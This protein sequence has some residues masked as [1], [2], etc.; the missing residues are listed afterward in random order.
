MIVRILGEGQFELQRARSPRWRS[1]TRTVAA[2]DAK[3]RRTF[4]DVLTRWFKKGAIEGNARPRIVFVP[5]KLTLATRERVTHE[6]RELLHPR[7]S[8]SPEPLVIPHS[9]S[10]NA[11]SRPHDSR[12][13][14]CR[15][16]F[17]PSS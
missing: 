7:T 2:L 4:R 15:A 13:S 14:S 11:G 10:R 12:Q 9:L 8:G 1:L 17:T 5:S 16:P 6:L 3:T